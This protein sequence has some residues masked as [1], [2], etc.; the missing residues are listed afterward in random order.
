VE[1]RGAGG[2]GYTSRT[3]DRLIIR[4]ANV[5][6]LAILGDLLAYRAN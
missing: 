5:E 2:I 6:D 3:D 4:C 1:I